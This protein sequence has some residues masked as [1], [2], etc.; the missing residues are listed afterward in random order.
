[1]APSSRPR[2]LSSRRP[3]YAPV[4][5]PIHATASGNRGSG[6]D[7]RRIQRCLK[8]APPLARTTHTVGPRPR[9]RSRHTGR[10]KESDRRQLQGRRAGGSEPPVAVRSARTPAHCTSTTPA[11]QRATSGLSRRGCGP[12]YC[13]ETGCRPAIR[14]RGPLRA[15]NRARGYRVGVPQTGGR[16]VC[17]VAHTVVIAGPAIRG[18]PGV[19]R[20]LATGC[21][22]ALAV[23]PGSP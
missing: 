3:I 23:P 8:G 1:M 9:V 15:V 19:G 2:A 17:V 14:C 22:C 5:G 16:P 4:C 12:A 20:A 18:I 13:Q 10:L 7:A 21:S 6:A 11:R